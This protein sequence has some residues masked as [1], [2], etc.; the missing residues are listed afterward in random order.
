MGAHFTEAGLR[1]LRGLKRNNDRD[2]FNERKP[3]Y[4]LELKQPLLALIEEINAG[5]VDYA[6]EH[7]RPPAKI[8]MRIY[9]DIRFAKDKRPY[10]THVSAWWA[11]TGHE[12]T[13]GGGFY[14]Q[15]A[16]DEVQIAA[17]VFLPERAQLLAIRSAIVTEHAR[18]RKELNHRGLKA[19]GLT[20][21]AGNP[22]TRPPKGFSG[23]PEAL[24]LLL[25]R[26][27]G[28]T[29]SFPAEMALAPTFAREIARRFARA[30]S[31]VA[32]LNEP[33]E[34][35]PKTSFFSPLPLR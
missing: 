10:K 19:A 28:V 3:V 32:L 24:D 15:L 27:W 11:K 23:P 21:I 4:E 31:L 8:M 34:T 6:P 26:E 12:K 20:A 18:L 33:L 35:R 5:M 14:V 2:W 29:G 9:R 16:G 30:A 22:L 17:G 1:F 25:C 7:V 13:S